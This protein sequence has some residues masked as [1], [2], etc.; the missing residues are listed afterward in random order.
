MSTSR[1]TRVLMVGA[2]LAA[3]NLAS[4]TAIAHANDGTP[5]IHDQRPPT[6]ATVVESWHQ[7]PAAGQSAAAGDTPRPP[8]EGQVGE[9]WHPRVIAPTPLAP[10]DGQPD[11]PIA[12]LTLLTAALA[13]FAGL[14]VKRASRNTRISHVT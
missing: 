4:M 13:L 9:P 14:A 2:L 11:W 8:T 7:R 5:T 1:L 10:P 3:T 6:Q 12:S